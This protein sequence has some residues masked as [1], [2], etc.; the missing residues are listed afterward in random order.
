MASCP[1]VVLLDV[2]G[3]LISYDVKNDLVDYY[4]RPEIALDSWMV[5]KIREMSN[6]GVA[7]Y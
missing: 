6:A 3:N 1:R 5:G 7:F 2:H 4:Q